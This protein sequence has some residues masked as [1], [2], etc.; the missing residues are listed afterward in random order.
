MTPFHVLLVGQ[1]WYK[2][3]LGVS[4][5]GVILEIAILSMEGLALSPGNLLAGW[6]YFGWSFTWPTY[7]HSL[8][9]YMYIWIA[10]SGNECFILIWKPTR[11]RAVIVLFVE[12]ERRYDHKKH[13]TL[14]KSC[15]NLS[16]SGQNGRHSGRR[17]FQMPFLVWEWYNSDSNFTEM[18]SW[19]SK[20]Q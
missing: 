7:S 18:C 20:W 2:S 10:M 1:L 16:S 5:V 3:P 9:T 14:K 13:V 6:A 19:E 4:A 11:E 17:H 15:V 12:P 8:A